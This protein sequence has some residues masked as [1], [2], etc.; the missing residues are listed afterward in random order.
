[1]KVFKFRIYPSSSQI[2]KIDK[3]FILCKDLYNSSLNSTRVHYEEFNKYIG[4]FSLNNTLPQI[5]KSFPEYQEIYSTILQN[6]ESRV[7][8]SMKS[9]FRRIK[10]KIVASII[11]EI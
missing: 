11:I 7:D 9:F 5:K 1:M 3:T 2:S 6:V 4:K 10:N 8:F